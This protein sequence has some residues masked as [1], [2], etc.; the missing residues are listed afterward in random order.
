MRFT[1]SDGTEIPTKKFLGKRKHKNAYD[2]SESYQNTNKN[3]DCDSMASVLISI[4][5]E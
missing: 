4:P 3:Q 2:Q 5:N 1:D